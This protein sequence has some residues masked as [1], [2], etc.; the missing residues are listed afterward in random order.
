MSRTLQCRIF[1]EQAIVVCSLSIV[2]PLHAQNAIVTELKGQ[3]TRA[4]DSHPEAPAHLL[5][6]LPAGATFQTL[7]DAHAVLVF[8]NGKRWEL[9]ASTKVRISAKG[10]EKIAGKLHQLP[11]L[12]PLPPLPAM[13]P[14]QVDSSRAGA[15]MWRSPVITGLFPHSPFLVLPDHVVLRFTPLKDA[16]AYDIVILD[17]QEKPVYRSKAAPGDEIEVPAGTLLPGRVYHWRVS[18]RT[19]RMPYIGEAHLLTLGAA[20]L[21]ERSRYLAASSSTDRDAAMARVSVDRQLGLLLEVRDQLRAALKQ[22]DDE[23]LRALLKDTEER[24]KANQ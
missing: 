3:A 15:T 20:K 12:T 9:N 1:V 8:S 5:D 24:M 16:S 14:G 6:W 18:T 11:A 2:L 7:S 10:V 22:Q 17:E 13:A 19:G 4:V 23:D 21:A